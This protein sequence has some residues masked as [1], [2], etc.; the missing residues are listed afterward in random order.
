M[1][2]DCKGYVETFSNPSNTVPG[3]ASQRQFTTT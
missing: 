3:Q 2:M 1:S